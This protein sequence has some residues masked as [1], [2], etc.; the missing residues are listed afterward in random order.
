MI[1][2]IYLTTNTINNKK[3]IGQRRW[4]NIDTIYEDMYLGSGKVLK[5]AIKK[6]GSEHFSKE[7]LCVC[8]TEEE[9]SQKEK[10]YISIYNAT[11]SN[12][13]YNIHEGGCGGNT[14][15]GYTEEEMKNFKLKMKTARKGYR[16]SEETKAKIGKANIGDKNH[17]KKDKYRKMFSEMFSG[18]RNPMY[19]RA[20]SEKTKAK[21]LESHNGFF[22][23]NK[24]KQMSDEQKDKI[25]TSMKEYFNN[26]DNREKWAKSHLGKEHSQE[27]KQKMS[28]SSYKRY[29]TIPY[30]DDIVIYKC[31]SDF[32]II[33]IF[34]GISEYYQH[35]K[36]KTCR[37]LKSAV[38]NKVMFKGYFWYIE[39]KSQST[40]E[41]TLNSGRE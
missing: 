30:D 7:I 28:M 17:M 10:E 5:Q 13:F 2:Y 18:D 25:S 37:N 3:Y 4:S 12:D 11:K 34:Y 32:N 38:K 19:G 39:V 40:I 15:K 23:Y 22:A 21:L 36:T 14:R 33:D 20:M 6:N 29:N 35:Y 16:H 27:T 9:L 24:G 26:E 1:G 8:Y 41:T 31:D